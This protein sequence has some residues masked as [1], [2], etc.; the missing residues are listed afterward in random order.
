M[1]KYKKN[2][3]IC[4]KNMLTELCHIFQFILN[5]NVNLIIHF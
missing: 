5:N 1:L 2:M 3:I 4:Y